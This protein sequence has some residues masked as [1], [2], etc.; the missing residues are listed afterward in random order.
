MI[1]FIRSIVMAARR[2][3]ER[4]MSHTVDATP[5]HTTEGVDER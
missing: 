2:L 3:G 1:L 5:H 4:R